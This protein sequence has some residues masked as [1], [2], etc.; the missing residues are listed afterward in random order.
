MKIEAFRLEPL[1]EGADADV[2]REGELLVTYT[3]DEI[4]KHSTSE[5]AQK[6]DSTTPKV[7]LQFE[8]SRSQFFK[9]LAIWYYF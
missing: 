3:L 4:R 2:E 7:S 6:E 9:L 5:I 1:E 8:L